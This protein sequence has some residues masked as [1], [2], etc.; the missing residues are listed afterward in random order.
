[1]YDNDTLVVESFRDEPAMVRVVADERYSEVVDITT[2][3]VFL[4]RDWPGP[5]RRPSHRKG[6]D[7][8]I[9]PHAYRMLRCR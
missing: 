1:L 3:Q 4:G 6:F 5:G 7:L 8:T 2:G 9:N